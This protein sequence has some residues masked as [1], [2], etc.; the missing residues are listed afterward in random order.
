MQKLSEEAKKNKNEYIKKYNKNTKTIQ[1][2]LSNKEYN[3]FME[4]YEKLKTKITY[5]QLMFKGL[6]EFLKE[7]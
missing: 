1:L 5:K 2:R 7:K 3:E 6:D 4:K